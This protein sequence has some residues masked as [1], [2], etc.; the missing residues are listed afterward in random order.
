MWSTSSR[1]TSARVVAG[2]AG[3]TLK[4][5]YPFADSRL[6]YST[7]R[8]FRA[9][10][11]W[12]DLPRYNLL[13][14]RTVRLLII[15]NPT[16]GQ[17]RRRRFEAVLKILAERGASVTL[18]ATARRGDAEEFARAA[19]TAGYDRVAVAGGDGTINE[20]INGLVGSQVALAI[21]PLGTANVLAAEIGLGSRPED[22]AAAILRGTPRPVALGRI[23]TA[24]RTRR[25]VMMAGIGFDAQV[26]AGVNPAL[27][28]L[29]GKF[30]YVAASLRALL[31][32]PGLVFRL[33][34]DGRVYHAAS[35]IVAK[36]HFYGGRFVACPE[37]RLEEPILHVCLFGRAGRL[38]ILRYAAALVL[39]FLPRLP[40][41]TVVRAKQVT[42]D[43]P[44]GEPVQV[45]GDSEGRLPATLEVEERA[46]TLVYP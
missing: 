23:T 13:Y 34:I 1:R 22:I 36:G 24:Q 19:V 46:L 12:R 7:Q 3:S 9:R 20:A 38:H 10:A 16:A 18:Q 32:D 29:T 43:G 31:R 37:A 35:A 2:G 44:P 15:Y 41:V 26:A 30:A 21:V 6:T 27:K 8:C 5:L 45:D 17:R 40:D 25:F 28:R 14:D 11:P 42:L 33:E 4:R 39:G